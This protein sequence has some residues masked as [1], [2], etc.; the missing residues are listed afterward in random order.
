MR[1][2]QQI[3]VSTI[4]KT[5]P[6]QQLRLHIITNI[7]QFISAAATKTT[8]LCHL[9]KPS[10]LSFVGYNKLESLEQFALTMKFVS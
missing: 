6:F 1:R 5:K 10:R 3:N 7:I 9:L 4:R 8:R 2:P